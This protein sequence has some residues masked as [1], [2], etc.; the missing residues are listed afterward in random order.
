MFDSIAPEYDKLNHIM[1]LDIDRTWRKRALKCIFKP[2]GTE[3]AM[4]AGGDSETGGL[5]VLDI[6]C[7]T[8]DFSIAIAREML[9]RA[10]A[11]KD[12]T[13][14]G[15]DENPSEGAIETHGA[16]TGGYWPGHVTGLDLSEGMLKIM[17]E[18]VKAEG[19]EKMISYETGDC[20]NLRFADGSFDRVT[21]AFGVRNFENR[22]KGLREMLRVLRP[23]GE[24]VILELSV[25]SNAVIR[26]FFNLY[27]L[28]ILPLIG[29]KVSGD[30]AAYKYL[31]A[32][33]LNFPGKKEFM[34]TLREC[35]F[36]SVRHKA[37]TLGICRMYS[38]EK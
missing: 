34:N 2:D 23:G 33:V 1:S 12:E 9:R 13:R 15:I 32:S 22:E 3:R 27:F 37:F 16:H 7:G 4:A 38:G 35:G 18:K 20:E 8:G 30:K 14:S 28:H 19:L 11:C 5:H 24:L 36:R 17:G 10:S 25:P 31:P 29:G 26:W 21:V 6:A